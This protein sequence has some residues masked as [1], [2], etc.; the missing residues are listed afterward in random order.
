MKK[1]IILFIVALTLLPFLHSGLFDVHDPTSAFRLYTLVQTLK[2]GQF[3]AAW[4]NLLNFGY[5]YPIH[6]YYAPLFTY[7]GSIFVPFVGSYEIAVKLSLAV[8][9]V[10]GTYGVFKLLQKYETYPAILAAVAFTFLPYRA[11]AIYVRGSYAEFLAMSLLP[12]VIYYWTKPQNTK[13][14]ILL[15]S[16]VTALFALSHNT[17]PVL[18]APIILLIIILFQQKFIKGSLYALLSAFGLCAWFILPVLFERSFVQVDK[19]ALITNYH[20]HFLSLSQLWYSAWGYGGS[21]IGTDAD[22]MSFMIGKG[23][24]IL[25]V[26]GLGVLA[27]KKL[28][29]QFILLAF[30]SIFAVFLSL[31]HSSFVW[32]IFPLLAVMQ[33]PWR[34]LAVVGVGVAVLSGFSIIAISN[35]LQL[36]A[37]LVL[38]FLL[39]VSNYKYFRPQ[40][41]RDYKLDILSSQGNL[42]PLV[43]DKIPEYLPK[44]MPHTLPRRDDGLT[45]NSTK[46]SGD[47]TLGDTGHIMINTA[48]TLQWQMYVGGEY[49]P[50]EPSKDGLIQTTNSFSSGKYEIELVWKRTLIEQIGIWITASSIMIMIGLLIL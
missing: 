39:I 2:T 5:G 25:S 41:Y 21:A 11:S 50:V 18:V 28:W 35:R 16:L 48:Y 47:I 33:F 9:S 46:V 24:L 26:V 34:S 17:L 29:K 14:N 12:W 40:E 43:K 3:P 36:I 10:V 31:S 45:R 27:I 38:S 7:L 8:S 23:Q 44:W 37:C 30:T 42:D 22:H 6:L 32:E 4:S 20:D 15:T 19:I 1:I 49:Q 13:K